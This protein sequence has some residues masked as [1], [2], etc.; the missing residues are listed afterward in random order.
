[1]RKGSGTALENEKTQL[2][3]DDVKPVLDGWANDLRLSYEKLKKEN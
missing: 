3:L 2:T 1:V